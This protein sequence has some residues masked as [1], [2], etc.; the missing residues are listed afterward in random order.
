MTAP[1]RGAASAD[2]ER[3][4]SAPASG[5][6]PAPVIPPSPYGRL[7]G[8]TRHAASGPT[9]S[10]RTRRSDGVA[11]T[12]EK[13]VMNTGSPPPGAAPAAH[14]VGPP[15]RGD[16]GRRPEQQSAPTRTTSA[17]PVP[18]DQPTQAGRGPRP[19]APGERSLLR[20]RPTRPRQGWQALAYGATG[21]RFNPGPGAKEAR[22]L[23]REAQ[24]ATQL[25]GKNVTAFFCLKGGVSKTSTTAATSIALSNLRPDPVFAIDANPDAGDLSERIVGRQLSG[26][27]DLAAAVDDVRSLDDLNRFTVTSG[28]LTVLPGEPSPI[29]GGSLRAA[30]FRR[31][32]EL[33]RRYYSFVQ[34]DCGTGVTHPLMGGILEYTDTVVVPAAWSITGARRAAETLDWLADNGFEHLARTSIVV[35]T[36]KDVVSRNV[37][38]DAVLE[39]LG[40]AADLIVVPADPHMADGALIDWDLLLPA[41]REAYLEIAAAITRRFQTP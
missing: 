29:L 41:T 39:H 9:H 23:D 40:R 5:T 14:P 6:S 18:F 30:D 27:S 37:D 26:I 32:M 21:G 2:D 38:K 24:I 13:I 25:R 10:D 3:A 31:V 36:A 17:S 35:L 34:V 7:K 4:S 15:R 8:P 16:A 28:R 22:R 12:T 11:R 19:S 33:V 20:R 1:Q